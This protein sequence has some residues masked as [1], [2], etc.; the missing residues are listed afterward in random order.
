MASVKECQQ[1]TDV[2]YLLH[3]ELKE[4]KNSL[5]LTKL[6]RNSRFLAC[7]IEI[8]GCHYRSL[9]LYVT[10]L[11]SQNIDNGS[12]SENYRPKG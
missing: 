6:E 3:V 9:F 8:K 2:K 4:E 7:K 1:L 5:S 11:E 12:E 10:I